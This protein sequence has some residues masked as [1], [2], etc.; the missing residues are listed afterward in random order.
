MLYVR[1][2]VIMQNVYK[3]YRI[4]IVRRSEESYEN[5]HIVL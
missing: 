1:H 3:D 5:L 2:F 4:K